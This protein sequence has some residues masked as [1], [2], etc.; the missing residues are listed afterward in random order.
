MICW[1]GWRWDSPTAF[2]FPSRVRAFINNHGPQPSKILFFALESRGPP[3]WRTFL[4]WSCRL[5]T[6]L[7]GSTGDWI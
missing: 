6:C 7:P 1:R 2:K 3:H 5:R 4:W